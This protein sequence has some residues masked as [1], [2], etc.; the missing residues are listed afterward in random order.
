MSTTQT[1]EQLAQLISKGAVSPLKR[2][3]YILIIVIASIS[4][5]FYV[6]GFFQK[7]PDAIVYD[8]EA[9]RIGD[10]SLSVRTAGNLAPTNQI[11]MGSELSGRV[12]EVLVDTN[13]LVKKGQILAKLDTTRTKQ[14]LLSIKANLLANHARVKQFEA[15]LAEKKTSLARQ[16]ELYELSGGKSP[17][18]TSLDT[19]RA[20]V[21]RAIADVEAAKANVAAT[22]AE[23]RSVEIDLEK[24]IIRSPVNGI[25]LSRTVEE[26]QTVAAS[27]TAPTLFTI[28]EDLK[29]MELIVNVSEADIGKVK[30]GQKSSFSVDAWPSR[31]FSATIK[32][33]VYGAVGTG[34][35][36]MVAAAQGN[37]IVSYSTELEVDNSDLTLR[38]GMTAIVA[39]EI[40]DK[41]DILLI[42]NTALR[43]NPEFALT[44][45]QPKEGG[46]TIVESFSSVT[47]RS[48]AKS[49]PKQGSTD[50]PPQVWVLKNG[51]P[52][53]VPITLGITDGSYTE[54]TS[55]NLAEGD[56]IIVSIKP[57]KSE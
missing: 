24:A 35:A 18:P 34:L 51:E 15:T 12:D 25:V 36:N 5:G 39:I 47:G 22:E 6:W 57:P 3:I 8:T 53:L 7:A 9:A 49:P 29:K 20:F 10:I 16:E 4:I 52:H 11:V 43:F 17:S 14:R 21:T 37:Q 32:K 27:F 28:A 31:I 44:A 26:G 40:I 23:V 42:P 50:A 13:D 55:D 45:I 1:P 56:Q 38:P 2:G 46:K 19:S 48:W 54:V 41:K 33:V 30:E